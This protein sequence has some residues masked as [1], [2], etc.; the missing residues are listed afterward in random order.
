MNALVAAYRRV[1]F[2][3]GRGT[4]LGAFL[5]C[6]LIGIISNASITWAWTPTSRS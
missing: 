1:T 4:V 6:L 2:E 5:G 3:A